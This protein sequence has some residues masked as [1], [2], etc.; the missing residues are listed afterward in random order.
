MLFLSEDYFLQNLTR[1][2]VDHLHFFV[3]QGGINHYF[4]PV[5]SQENRVL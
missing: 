4:V 1:I 2:S 5:V 3:N